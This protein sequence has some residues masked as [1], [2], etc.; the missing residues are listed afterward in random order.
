MSSGQTTLEKKIASLQALEVQPGVAMRLIE[1]GRNPKAELEEYVELVSLSPALAS[2][3]IAFANS[4]WY[5]PRQ[6][7]TT[8]QRA[9]TMIGSSQVRALAISFCMAGMLDSFNLAT[10]DAQAYW[11]ASLFKA[12]GAK[13]LASALDEKCA[14]EA[15]SIGLMQDMGLILLVSGDDGYA[16]LLKDPTFQLAEQLDYEVRWFGMDH[17]AVGAAVARSF[18]L[19][20]LYE[21]CIAAQHQQPDSVHETTSDCVAVSSSSVGWLPHDMRSWKPRDL[22]QFA[23]VLDKHFKS[24]WT[25]TSIF[26]ADVQNEF[27]TL[28]Q[29]LGRGPVEPADLMK[30]LEEMSI[31]N[32]SHVSTQAGGRS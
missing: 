19:P 31:E 32:K 22:G 24:R 3:L 20:I 23:G 2:K 11:E 30:Q 5:S 10:E 1:L 14:D 29:R 25:A 17:A 28:L 13:R 7:I 8:I 18:G 12:V 27:Q 4:S 9:L 21:A 6:P 26:V 16:D 15:F